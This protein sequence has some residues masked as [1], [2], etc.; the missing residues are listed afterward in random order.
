MVAD[1]C[2][3]SHVM[4]RCTVYTGQPLQ[5]HQTRQRHQTFESRSGQARKQ[6]ERTLKRCQVLHINLAGDFPSIGMHII[7]VFTV[8]KAQARS[9]VHDVTAWILRATYLDMDVLFDPDTAIGNPSRCLNPLRG[10]SPYC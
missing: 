5:R 9:W 10:T 8:N 6:S 1:T 4:N 3:R 2:M 7:G